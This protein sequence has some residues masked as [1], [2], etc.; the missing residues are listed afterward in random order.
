MSAR[1]FL[2]LLGAHQMW[3][4]WQY[5]PLKYL[6]DFFGSL[7]SWKQIIHLCENAEIMAVLPF[8][9]GVVIFDLIFLSK[10]IT[11]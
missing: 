6:G 2:R 9:K 4:I 5:M 11:K 8:F 1:D 7:L 3:S 10:F